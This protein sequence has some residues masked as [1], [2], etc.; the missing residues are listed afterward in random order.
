MSLLFFK[1]FFESARFQ[2]ARYSGIISRPENKKT[3]HLSGAKKSNEINNK[4]LEFLTPGSGRNYNS[5]N[6]I[7]SIKHNLIRLTPDPTIFFINLEISGKSKID[8]IKPMTFVFCVDTSGSMNETLGD[9]NDREMSAYTREDMVKHTLKT[10]ISTLRPEDQ[11]G[12]VAFSDSSN[13]IIGLTNMDPNGKQKAINTINN[14]SSHGNTNLWD[15]V[16]RLANR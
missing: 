16:R 13:E 5:N 15:G 14:I 2:R 7:Y 4:I 6:N 1:R 8:I 10:A 12:A 11:F 3:N 9:K